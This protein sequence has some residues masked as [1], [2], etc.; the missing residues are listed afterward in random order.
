MLSTEIDQ[1]FV[2]KNG[3]CGNNS[4][5]FYQLTWEID[6]SEK[7]SRSLSSD[8]AFCSDGDDDHCD[9]LLDCIRSSSKVCS[10]SQRGNS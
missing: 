8:S 4:R 9:S 7:K 6:N 1:L 10:Q 5:I 3:V 2:N